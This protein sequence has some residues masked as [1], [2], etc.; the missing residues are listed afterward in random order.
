MR[1]IDTEITKGGILTMKQGT[2]SKKAEEVVEESK[3]IDSYGCYL[4]SLLY[5]AYKREPTFSEILSNYELLLEYDLIDD[6]CF[7]KDPC[8]VLKYFDGNDWKVKKTDTF[9]RADVVIAYYFNPRTKLHHFVLMDNDNK[10]LWDPLGN[11]TT[12]EEGFIESYRLFWR[13]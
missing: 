12:V 8:G 5:F 11:S 2:I 3:K 9:E 4:M 1:N 13:A 6:D 10:V 7:V